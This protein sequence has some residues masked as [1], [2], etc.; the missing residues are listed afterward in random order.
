LLTKEVLLLEFGSGL[1]AETVPVLPI[2][3]FPLETVR[4][5][6]VA[7]SPTASEPTAQLTVRV[8]EVHEQVP[9]V[10]VADWKVSRLESTSLTVTPWAA[11]GPRLEARS[12]N[13]IECLEPVD[14]VLTIATSAEG[15][16]VGVRVGVLLGVGVRVR[17]GVAL[18]VRLAVG[19][20]VGVGVGTEAA[21]TV[22][23]S[24][25]AVHSCELSW[26]VTARPT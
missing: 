22:T 11:F 26:L 23:L 9:F 16:G 5:V 4:I 10:V 13:V 20:L 17:V 18:G 8:P 14:A 2:C 6:T 24:K 21:V 1:V 7:A 12:V 3:D 25:T 19:V 15:R